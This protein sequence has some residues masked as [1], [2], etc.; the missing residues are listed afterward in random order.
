MLIQF[1]NKSLQFWELGQ[2]SDF[3]VLLWQMN[4]P[5][6][7]SIKKK[8]T[9]ENIRFPVCLAWLPIGKCPCL[10]CNKYF[11]VMSFGVPNPMAYYEQ[12]RKIYCLIKWSFKVACSRGVYSEADTAPMFCAAILAHCPLLRGTPRIIT[13][14]W[15]EP[16][17]KSKGRK[18]ALSSICSSFHET[19]L[20]DIISANF[21]LYL[22]G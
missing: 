14:W 16:G 8:K 21:P 6:S 9:W 19:L 15:P 2:T 12:I 5:T 7:Y 3:K 17:T 13:R 11:M 18:W 1:S 4:S 10:G 20:P 22:V